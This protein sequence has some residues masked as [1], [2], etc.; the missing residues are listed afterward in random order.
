MPIEFRDNH[1][2]GWTMWF[3]MSIDGSDMSNKFVLNT[4]VNFI[5]MTYEKKERERD[6]TR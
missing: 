1:T 4:N 6:I 2:F 5:S 3:A